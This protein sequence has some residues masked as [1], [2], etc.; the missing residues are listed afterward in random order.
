MR[1]TI[2]GITV[3]VSPPKPNIKLSK[4]R[5]PGI[6]CKFPCECGIAKLSITNDMLKSLP[7]HQSSASVFGQVKASK[8]YTAE[9][10]NTYAP[11]FVQYAEKFQ[12]TKQKWADKTKHP[13]YSTTMQISCDACKRVYTVPAEFS[14]N[15]EPHPPLTHIEALA[16]FG[17]GESNK[18]KTILARV[19]FLKGFADWR[20]FRAHLL[21][22]SKE[23]KIIHGILDSLGNHLQK[24]LKKNA[25]QTPTGQ[26]FI[27]SLALSLNELHED[28][29]QKTHEK[30]EALLRT[31]FNETVA[32]KIEEEGGEKS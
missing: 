29:Q 21:N 17:F 8:D 2:D 6:V 1:T 28:F 27:E 9:L 11:D 4:S 25:P 32:E 15:L 18:T 23:A 12:L 16:Q 7:F 30:L 31:V 20:E 13:R 19:G 24:T 5:M 22:L 10:H 3:E 26:K 14:H